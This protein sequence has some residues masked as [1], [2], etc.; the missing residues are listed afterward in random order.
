MAKFEVIEGDLSGPGIK[1]KKEEDTRLYMKVGD[2]VMFVLGETNM[3]SAISTVLGA[4]NARPLGGG[5]DD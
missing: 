3:A 2:G 5:D 4:L 1:A